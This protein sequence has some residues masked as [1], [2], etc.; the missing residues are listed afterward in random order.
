M[1]LQGVPKPQGQTARDVATAHMQA[2]GFQ[3]VSGD[4]TTLNGLDAFVGV[5]QGTIDGLGEVRSRAAHIAHGGTYYLVAGLVAPAGFDSVDG[6]FMSAIR[7]F[8]PLTTAEAQAIR[9]SRVDFY[10]VRDGDTWVSLAE[11]SGGAIRPSTLAVMNHS[12]PDTA[13]RVGARVRIVV[14]G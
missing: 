7:S 8:R 6:A 4:R 2:A 9:P 3:A 10:T 11:R 13:P 1:L 14:A 12:L 5:Y